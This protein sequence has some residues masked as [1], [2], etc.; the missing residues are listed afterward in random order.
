MLVTFVPFPQT[1]ARV[2]TYAVAVVRVLKAG[3]AEAV[4]GAHRVL[5]GPVATGLPLALVHV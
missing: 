2:R 3:V 5:A 4:V 1:G